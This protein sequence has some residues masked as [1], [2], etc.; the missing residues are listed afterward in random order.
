LLHKLLSQDRL[1]SLGLHSTIK[2][3]V[4]VFTLALLHNTSLR[5]LHLDIK[6]FQSSDLVKIFTDNHTLQALKLPSNR[7]LPRDVE[8]ALAANTSLTCIDTWDRDLRR[9]SVVARHISIAV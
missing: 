6:D 2:T 9:G 7:M 1:H 3:P 8:H 4:E 5:A